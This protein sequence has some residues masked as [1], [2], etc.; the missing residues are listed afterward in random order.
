M[1]SKRETLGEKDSETKDRLKRHGK[2]DLTAATAY[3]SIIFE[4]QVLE[5]WI[6]TPPTLAE[7]ELS[8]GSSGISG[9]IRQD[10]HRR[11]GQCTR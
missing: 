10:C 8:G 2:Y 9:R 11:K 6:A 4:I 3:G 5:D 1:W 7:N